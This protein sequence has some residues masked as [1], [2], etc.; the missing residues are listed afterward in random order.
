MIV[1]PLTELSSKLK[2][3]LPM[4]IFMS[5]GAIVVELFYSIIGT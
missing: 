4:I 1:H 5:C 2:S 3:V